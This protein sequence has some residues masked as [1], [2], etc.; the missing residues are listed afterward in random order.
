MSISPIVLRARIR[1]KSVGPCV[2]VRVRGFG[3]RVLEIRAR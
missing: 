3:S 1:E 2:C